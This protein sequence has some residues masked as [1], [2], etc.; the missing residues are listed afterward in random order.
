MRAAA[1]LRGPA[2]LLALAWLLTGCAAVSVSTISPADYLAERRGDVL[3]TGRLSGA[4][5]EV[6]RVVGI[7][8]CREQPAACRQTL[9]AVAGI[10]DEQRL[11]A[12]SELWLE[13][14]LAT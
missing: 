2:L 12:L 7:A 10:T 3:T 11:S 4:A 8:D 13:H 1:L 9:A 6:L 5:Q 14:A